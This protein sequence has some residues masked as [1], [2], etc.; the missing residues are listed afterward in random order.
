MNIPTVGQTITALVKPTGALGDTVEKTFEGTVVP[1]DWLK[2]NQFAMSTGIKDFPI[3]VINIEHVIS[4]NGGTVAQHEASPIT[5]RIVQG[6]KGATYTVS[7]I[8]IF[9]SNFL[10]LSIW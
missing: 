8:T 10:N 6:S 2:D 3:R 1:C 9:S 5:T 4:I 7:K